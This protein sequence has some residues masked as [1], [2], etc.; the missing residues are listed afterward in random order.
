[1]QTVLDG[2]YVDAY[3]LKHPREPGATLPTANPT[4]RLDY[5]FVPQ[6][7]SERLAACDVVRHPD[8]VKA[9]DHFPVVA[10][11]YD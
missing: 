7:Y 10:D 5:V 4:V 11:L 8:G 3:R 1:M 6:Q 2:G 9:S